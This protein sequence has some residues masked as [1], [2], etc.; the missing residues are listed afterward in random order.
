MTPWKSPTWGWNGNRKA[1]RF[2][3]GGSSATNQTAQSSPK[4]GGF[5]RQGSTAGSILRRWGGGTRRRDAGGPM[6]WRQKH[7]FKQAVMW[8]TTSTCR[9]SKMFLG[10][11]RPCVP[12]QSLSQHGNSLWLHTR[13]SQRCRALELWIFRLHWSGSSLGVRTSVV[14]HEIPMRSPAESHWSTARATGNLI[15]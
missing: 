3:L 12:L 11:T 1:A 7:S 5:C 2:S 8:A 10:A 4:E 14:A 6:G 15:F 9:F 13:G